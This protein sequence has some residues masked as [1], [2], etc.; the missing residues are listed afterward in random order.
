MNGTTSQLKRK[1]MLKLAQDPTIFELIDNK[2]IDKEDCEDLIYTNIFPY[3]RVNYTVQEVGSYICVKLNYPEVNN[4]EIFKNAELYFYVICNNGC[5]KTK[6][7]Y[8]RTDLIAERILE[9]FDWNSEL[10]FRLELASEREDPIDD[11]FYYKR[12]TFKSFS[13]NGVK[14]GVKIN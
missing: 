9:L 4:N 5:L 14:N 13:P 10:G 6:S 8:S 3:V 7:G 11:N 12:L 1:I 2:D